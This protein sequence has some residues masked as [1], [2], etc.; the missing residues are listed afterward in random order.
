M[1]TVPAVRNRVCPRTRSSRGRLRL[2]PLLEQQP[3]FERAQ[4]VDEQDPVEVIDL[5]L[6]DAS[7]Q[8]L[9]FDATRAAIRI[10]AFDHAAEWTLDNILQAGNAET[11]FL[12]TL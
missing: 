1:R 3:A 9:R 10:L 7:E 2:L 12:A 4:P 6:Q 11:A 8:S 5:V